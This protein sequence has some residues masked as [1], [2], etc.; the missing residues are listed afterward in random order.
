MGDHL[1]SLNVETNPMNTF[2]KSGRTLRFP[3]EGSAHTLIYV[4]IPELISRFH[5]ASC[6][7]CRPASES[8]S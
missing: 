1:E 7:V 6:N 3:V 5:D 4:A 8:W 2:N